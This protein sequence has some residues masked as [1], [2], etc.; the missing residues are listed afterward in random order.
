MAGITRVSPEK[1]P[2]TKTG[3]ARLPTKEARY[4]VYDKGHAE[5]V[6][7]L[8][9]SVSPSGVRSFQVYKK[10]KGRPKRV[11]LGRFP[12]MTVSQ[13]RKHAVRVIGKLAD[14][15]DVVQERRA[16]RDRGVTLCQALDDY[17]ADRKLRPATEKMYR[18]RVTQY[19]GDWL[20]RPLAYITRER[21]ARRHRRN[22]EKS[23]TSANKVM[24]ILRAIF[25]YA[26]GEYL[27]DEGKSQFP[28]NPVRQLSHKRVWNKESRR[29]GRI[30]EQ[31]LADWF[32]AVNAL[33]CCFAPKTDPGVA[34]N[35]DPV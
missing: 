19:L 5:S 26:S 12:G 7:G 29:S 20:D 15:I 22:S 3:I 24:R 14:G 28:D 17:C 21:V 1:I 11:T 9:V 10:F 35:T 6:N 18:D 23:E 27:D 33:E 16:E 30:R 32:G 8:L 34:L 31:D 13:A 4:Y 2:F 25:E